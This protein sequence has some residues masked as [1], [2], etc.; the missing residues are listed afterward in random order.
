[1]NE[2]SLTPPQPLT[3]PLAGEKQGARNVRVLV[4]LTVFLDMVGY[5][6]VIPLLPLYVRSMH[7][8]AE[9]V[10]LILTSFALTQ[11][12]ATPVLGRLSD[13]YGRR[14][15][16]LLSLAGNAVAMGLFSLAT[17]LEL[18]PLLF[19]SRIFAGATSG[20]LS[21]CQAAIADT[22][23]GADRAKAMG[24]IGG[25]IGVGMMIGPVAG[26][27]LSHL[28]PWVPPL[29]AGAFALVDMALVFFFLPETRR[30]GPALQSPQSPQALQASPASRGFASRAQMRHVI[31]MPGLSLVLGLYFLTFLCMSNMQVAL[32]LLAHD[33]FAW[34]E[35]DVGHLFGLFGLIGLV[36]QLWL[37]GPLVRA[38]G[39]ARLVTAGSA[40]IG[41]GLLMIGLAHAPS[42]LIGGLVLMSAGVGV[43]N[44]TLAALASNLAPEGRQGVVLGVAQSSGGLA[45][46]IGPT[47]SGALYA[48]AGPP[49]PFLGGVLAA[50]VASVLGLRLSGLAP[51]KPRPASADSAA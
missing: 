7:G 2:P 23:T 50:L 26:G 45:R 38:V 16:I 49:A 27:L 13:R 42:S 31:A 32:A 25:G 9:I 20:N 29:A 15:V 6:I 41:T 40:L 19:A 21:A 3:S 10:G 8:S 34:D 17:R 33:R 1:V 46:T 35:S 18:L 4:F 36:V 43:V 44:P 22:A 14:P 48:H 47:L 30:S 12:V 5:G 37:I 39:Q 51:E 11:L 24:L 28:G